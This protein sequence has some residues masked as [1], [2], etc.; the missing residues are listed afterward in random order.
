MISNCLLSTL[1]T[2]RCDKF[3]A[4]LNMMVLHGIAVPIQASQVQEV[5]YWNGSIALSATLLVPE[6]EGTVPCV[7]IIHGSGDSDRENAW[8]S[9]YAQAFVD[10]GIA[11]LHPDKRGCGRSGGDWKQA[12]F[13]DLAGDASAALRFIAS[14]SA[15]D[16]TRSGVVGFSQGSYVASLVVEDPLCYFAVS[17]SG[18]VRSLK[19]QM[20]DEV[21][22]AAIRAGHVPKDDDLRS[23]TWIYSAT[24]AFAHGQGEWRTLQDSVATGRLRGPFL[25]HALSSM[26]LSSDH[27]ALRWVGHVGDHDPWPHWLRTIKPVVFLFGGRDE[28]VNVPASMVRIMESNDEKLFRRSAL[29]FGGNG[30]ALFRTDAMDFIT[31]WIIE[32]GAD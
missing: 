30:H 5:Q 19:E 23:L 21:T 7:V 16:P 12:S 20:I 2:L 29:V 22:L 18:S 27:W 26:P 32:G 6:R 10:R 15:I 24:F 3:V 13:L 25:D 8:T 9:A 31:R 1:R 4:T 14:H 11:V 28:N 17:V